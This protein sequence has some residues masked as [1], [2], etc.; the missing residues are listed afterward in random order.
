MIMPNP[1]S[2][3]SLNLMVL[4]AEI[5]KILKLQKSYILVEDVLL[6]FLDKDI[7]RTPDMFINALI[8]LY[9]MGIINKKDYKIKLVDRNRENQLKI[10]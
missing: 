1:N 5:I 9:G 6:K 3:F 2:N 8:F 4:G 7:N 10:F